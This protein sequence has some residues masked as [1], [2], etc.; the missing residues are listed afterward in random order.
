MKLKRILAGS[1]TLGFPNKNPTLTL[2]LTTDA[3]D[4][5]Y[6][7][8]KPSRLVMRSRWAI[9]LEPFKMPQQDGRFGRRNFTHFIVHSTSNP[10][11]IDLV[12]PMP[13]TFRQ[14]KYILTVVCEFSGYLELISLPDKTA[15]A[16]VKGLNSIVKGRRPVLP[17]QSSNQ[18]SF[19]SV[20]G[21]W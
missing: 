14:N 1:E 19:M 13:T 7:Y 3:S 17:T 11:Q 10:A 8:P 4:V 6:G 15:V 2:N 21:R 20:S 16:V 5:E 9:W 12:G 18:R